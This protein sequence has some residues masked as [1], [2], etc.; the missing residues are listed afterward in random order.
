MSERIL[1]KADWPTE[2]RG[3]VPILP[4]DPRA[5]YQSQAAKAAAKRAARPGNSLAHLAR[6]RQL[7]C[8]LGHERAPQFVIHAHH[9][10]GFPTR[11]LRG[12]GLRA[13]DR[14]TVP[15]WSLR[16]EELHALGSR[17]EHAYF[18]AMGIDPYALAEALWA[19]TASLV[20]M[21]NVLAAHQVQAV[22]I[23]QAR[24]GK[25][26]DLLPSEWCRLATL[27]QLHGS[28]RLLEQHP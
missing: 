7:W 6:I 21:A 2:V 24:G 12:L 25:A 5:R 18:D 16:H 10:Q 9:L 28:V 20:R 11:K 8:T 13:P 3:R 27:S 19:N 22:G 1:S 4:R 23:L 15:L 14:Y 17:N 26:V